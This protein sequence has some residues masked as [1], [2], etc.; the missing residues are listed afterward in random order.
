MFYTTRSS[1]AKLTVQWSQ[2]HAAWL[3]DILTR[4]QV[5]LELQLIFFIAAPETESQVDL[6]SIP[7]QL[8]V[9]AQ[10]NSHLSVFWQV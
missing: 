7:Y 4:Q 9:L 2:K 5:E 6:W 1:A 3:L 8:L 10:L